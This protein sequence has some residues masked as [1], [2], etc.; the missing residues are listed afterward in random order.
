MS[1]GFIVVSPLVALGAALLHHAAN[2]AGTCGPYATDIPAHPCGFETY[3]ANF[4]SPFAV[5][6]MLV[7]TP[8]VMI[9]ASVLVAAI[10]GGAFAV[11]ALRRR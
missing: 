3:V 11:R 6:G 10:W 4:F 8:V 9:A 1:A 7:L 2:F 5:M